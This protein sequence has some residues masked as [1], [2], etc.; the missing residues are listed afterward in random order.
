MNILKIIN[1]YCSLF[2]IVLLGMSIIGCEKLVAVDPPITFVTSENVYSD[3]QTAI[4]TV[5]EIYGR[6]SGQLPNGQNNITSISTFTGLSSDELAVLPAQSDQSFQAY[7]KNDL[8]TN[9]PSNFS[10]SLWIPLYQTANALTSMVEGLK[11]Q[12]T[13]MENASSNL[14]SAVKIQLLGEA[15][16][17]RAFCYFYLVNLF[18]DVPLQ[19]TTNALEN[20]KKTKTPAAEVYAQIIKDLLD[21]KEALSENYLAGNLSSTSAD[22]IRPNKWAAAALLSRVYLYTGNWVAAEQE[23]TEV[24]DR[25]AIYSL[26]P[27]ATAFEKSSLEAIF[28]LQPVNTGWNTVFGRVLILTASGPTVNT[29]KPFYLNETLVNSFSANDPRR[30]QWISGVTAGGNTYYYPFKYKKGLGIDG[31]ITSAGQMTE[32]V[33]LLRLGEQYLIRAEARARQDRLSAAIAD[34]NTI[35]TR[36]RNGGAATVVPDYPLALNQ[37]EVLDAISLERKLELFTEWGDRWLDLKRTG[38]I[39]AVMS[40]ATPLKGGGDWRP[41]QAFYPIRQQEILDNPNLKQNEGY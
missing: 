31:T 2:I 8:R 7:F 11:A 27:L 35:R 29:T 25:P 34:I 17:M 18:G 10:G 37:Q 24:I 13:K 41:H 15:K 36:A 16:F 39:N 23:A 5:T 1:Q 30:S 38:R 14:T 9:M 32:Y 19:L 20:S 28:Q 40:G 21:A 6:I 3:N 26:A 22:R 12:P 4:A 33:M